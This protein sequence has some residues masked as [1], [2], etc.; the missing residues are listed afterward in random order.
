MGGGLGECFGVY[1]VSSNQWST[2]INVGVVVFLSLFDY[3]PEIHRACCP[4]RSAYAGEVTSADP[5]AAAA[6]ARHAAWDRTVLALNC[7]VAM[8]PALARIPD[9]MLNSIFNA[10]C[11][12]EF[13]ASSSSPTRRWRGPDLRVRRVARVRDGGRNRPD[14]IVHTE[15]RSLRSASPD[16]SRPACAGALAA[17]SVGDR[18]ATVDG[19]SRVGTDRG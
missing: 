4:P 6:A 7:P 1:T 14:P 19:A 5:Q 16:V 12:N 2:V 17:A 9:V 3:N 18:A 8:N 13:C 15:F 11:C 10:R